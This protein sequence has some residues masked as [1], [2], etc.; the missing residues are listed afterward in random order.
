PQVALTFTVRHG[1]QHEDTSTE[2]HTET[3]PFTL[4]P[5]PGLRSSIVC[6]VSE[7]DAVRLLGLEPPALAR[8]LERRAF[9]LLGAFEMD[10][11]RGAFPLAAETAERLTAPRLALVAEAAHVMPPIGAQGLN[12]G[13][14]DAA[15]LVG[16]AAEAASFG[17]DPGSESV[18]SRYASG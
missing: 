18:L 7:R 8:E 17:D 16:I 3:G 13:L 11:A 5:L 14:R 10:E 1:R 9:S 12:L 6:V 4:V 2:F 15:A